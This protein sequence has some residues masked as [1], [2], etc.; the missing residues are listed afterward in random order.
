[1]AHS[2]ADDLRLSK[3]TGGRLSASQVRNCKSASLVP[4][5]VPLDDLA[6]AWIALAEIVGR[7]KGSHDMAALRWAEVGYGSPRLREVL[8]Q[9]LLSLEPGETDITDVDE[10]VDYGMTGPIKPEFRRGAAGVA[11]GPGF[12]G[13]VDSPEELADTIAGSAYLVIAQATTGEE[14][15]EHDAADLHSVVGELLPSP[16]TRDPLFSLRETFAVLCLTR[17]ISAGVPAW[18][19]E[20]SLGKLAQDVATAARFF[21]LIAATAM[22]G[23]PSSISGDDRWLWIVMLAPGADFLMQTV[24]TVVRNLVGDGI[25][26]PTF[27]EL[28]EIADEMAGRQQLSAAIGVVEVAIEDSANDPPKGYPS[29]HSAHRRLLS[30]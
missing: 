3:L 27:E 17:E 1:M 18:V 9:R 15:S 13:G 29:A 25:A 28:R 30:E 22:L 6:D 11:Q 2:T 12:F 16:E 7:G 26:P 5:D 4:A 21:D 19:N 24:A 20:S 8:R 10:L 14:F 23:D